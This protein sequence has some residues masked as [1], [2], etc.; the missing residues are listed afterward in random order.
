MA[1]IRTFVSIVRKILFDEIEKAVS[2]YVEENFTKLE[3][4]SWRIK[5]VDEAF[6]QGT[7]LHRVIAYDS[8]DDTLSFDAVV[9][10]DIAIFQ[11]KVHSQ[12][13]EDETQKWFRVSCDVDVGDDFHNLRIKEIDEYN[14]SENDLRKMLDDSL[15]PFIHTVD[16][17]KHAEAILQ[18]VY[19][20]ALAEPTKIDVR[21]FAKRLGLDIEERRLS[22]NGTIF[23]QMI[24]HDATVE[25]FDLE[26]R[27]FNT[28]EAKGGTIF[29]DPEIYFLRSIG[30]WNN[31]VIHECVHWLKH[32]KHIALERALGTYVNRISCQ[33][34][35]VSYDERERDQADWMEWHANA[36]APRILMPRESFKQKAKEVIEW[37][38]EHG[39]PDNPADTIAAAIYELAEFFE[40]SAQSAKIRLLDIG[41]T[42]VIG[43]LEYIDGQYVQSHGFRHGAIG[44]DQTYTIPIKEGL[45]QYAVNKEFR[46]II[47]TGNF[48]YIDGHYCLND[49]NYVTHNEYGVLEMTQYALENIDECCLVFRRTSRLNP[50]YGAKRYSESVLFQS[51]VAKTIPEYSYSNK[52]QGKPIEELLAEISEANEASKIAAGL[53]RDFG[54]A[55]VSLMKWRKLSNERLAENALMHPKT[56]QRL[57]NNREPDYKTETVV[58]VCIGLQLYP[59]IS[60]EL[61]NLAGITLKNT[62]K[63]ILYFHILKTR[64][65]STIHECNELLAA[66][67]YPILTG[68]E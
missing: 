61:L 12:A 27:R 44:K 6:V 8:L 17:D 59:K 38:K 2:E 54:G 14:H 39:Q 48:I 1:K 33:V 36:L 66:A 42:E 60:L 7:S 4:Q 50:E 16:L 58:A 41:Y 23:G 46:Q 53:P 51:A 45:F 24:F 18:Y 11:N 3:L 21:L 63:D 67:N 65:K 15:V 5:R 49:P 40:V 31:T 52:D 57:R 43:V 10:T 35:E 25:Y 47:D 37:Y 22:R 62:E 55:L 56:I 20:E 30:S 9:I 32:R 26:R 13:I 34:S 28:F 29:A 68:I 19:P 64:Y